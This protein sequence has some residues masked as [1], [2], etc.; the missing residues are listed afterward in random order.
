M[1]VTVSVANQECN[2]ISDTVKAGIKEHTDGTTKRLIGWCG[3]LAKRF[4]FRIK[5]FCF[6]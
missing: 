2:T 5:S 1:N 3:E 6:T 4:H